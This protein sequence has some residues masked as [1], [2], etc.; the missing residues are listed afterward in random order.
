M[1]TCHHLAPF[2]PL[3]DALGYFGE[4]PL[5]FCQCLFFLPKEARIVDVGAIGEIGKRFEAHV[6]THLLIR[7]RQHCWLDLVSGEDHIP[8]VRRRAQ[9]AACLDHAFAGSVL[10]QLNVSDL[11]KAEL[12]LL[13]DAKAGLRIRQRG[14]AHPGAKAWIAGLLPRLNPAEENP[15]GFVHPMQ[16]I[17]QDL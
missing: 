6:K 2:G 13:I 10:H 14:I 7:R 3:R 8:L 12:A 11:G 4:L 1:Q 17:L 15:K 9:D 16:D 5:H